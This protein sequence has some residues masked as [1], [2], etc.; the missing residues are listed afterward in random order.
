MPKKTALE[1]VQHRDKDHVHDEKVALLFPCHK[2]RKIFCKRWTF[3]SHKCPNILIES[4]KTGFQ[5]ACELCDEKFVD[6][7][8]FDCH[9]VICQSEKDYR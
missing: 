1:I 5:Y 4:L 2:C 6:K 8:Q 3:E 7:E 9:T